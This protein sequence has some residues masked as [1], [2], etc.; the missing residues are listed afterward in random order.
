MTALFSMSMIIV[1][2]NLEISGSGASLIVDISNKLA[3]PLGEFG[4]WLFLIGAAGTVFSSLLGTWQ[5]TPYFFADS[6]MLMRD[7][8]EQSR[9][10]IETS[11]P[12]YRY[13]LIALALVPMLGLFFE[14]RQV[15][16]FYA[17]TGA[18]F[19]PMLAIVLLILNGQKRWVGARF[20]NRWPT[21][22]GL[23]ATIGFFLWVALSRLF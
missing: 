5:A 11:A 17:V 20:Q 7:P 1:G 22:A 21:I 8:A 19:V 15:Q 3:E 6:W 18:F 12:A 4:R 13:Y 14:F 10:R 23:V 2:S 16:K 9:D